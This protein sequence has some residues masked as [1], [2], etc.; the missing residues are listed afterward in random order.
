MYLMKII[1]NAF[2][3]SPDITGTDRMAHNF[4]EQLQRLDTESQYIIVCSNEAYN[5]SAINQA[6]FRII[7]P[8][9][10][11]AGRLIQRAYNKLW[12]TVLP[13]RLKA[14]KADTYV[15]F[16]NMSLPSTRVAK[17]M[18]AYNLDLIPIVI[19]G[20]ESIHRKPKAELVS[21]YKRV[22]ELA[23]HFISIS[24]F[25]KDELCRELGISP[26]IVSVVYLAAGPKFGE[27]T[28]LENTS[29]QSKKYLLTIGGTEPRKNVKTIVDAF[30]KLPEALQKEYPLVIMGGE[31]H[32]ISLDSFKAHPN[33]LCL[34]Y[35]SDQELP[36][37]YQNA[38]AFIFASEY[39]GFGFTVLEAMASGVPVIS[40]ESSSLTEVA[41][42]AALLFKP[43]DVETLQD[44]IAT[45]LS[46]PELV[47]KLVSSGDQRVKQFS[48]ENSA[49]K[50]HEILTTI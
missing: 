40:A 28:Q 49:K 7:R 48:W 32:G 35:V 43:H 21:D 26:E 34:G 47:K 27:K 3:Y 5:R 6:N 17:K 16:H 20:Y 25:S 29:I 30:T 37:L 33:V 50:L 12:R 38:K 11:P 15:S 41:G 19:P 9:R 46:D 8:L 44:H 2:Q 14:F 4:L 45:L 42:D 18:V 24:S 1:I 31:W 36:A 23:D 13:W 39:E 22:A 10:I